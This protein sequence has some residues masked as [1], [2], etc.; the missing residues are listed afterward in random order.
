[1]PTWRTKRR[2]T[3]AGWGTFPPWPRL[4]ACLGVKKKMER[5]QNERRRKKFIFHV[6]TLL[7]LVKLNFS[8]AFPFAA[9]EFC[10]CLLI[11]ALGCKKWRHFLFYFSCVRS[12]QFHLALRFSWE[13]LEV[14]KARNGQL[15]GLIVYENVFGKTFSVQSSRAHFSYLRSMH[16]VSNF[17]TPTKIDGVCRAQSKILFKYKKNIEK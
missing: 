11:S 9:R 8:F 1:L 12:S 17:S 16:K 6:I 10:F 5:N 3:E 15:Q 7:W 4:A 14:G 13:K 2:E